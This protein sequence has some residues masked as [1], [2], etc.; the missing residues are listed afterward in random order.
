MDLCIFALVSALLLPVCEA[1][2]HIVVMRNQNTE[3]PNVATALKTVLVLPH[4]SFS[5]LIIY[6]YLWSKQ[7]HKAGQ[8]ISAKVLIF[9]DF[10]RTSTGYPVAMLFQNTELE[11]IILSNLPIGR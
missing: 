11:I 6:C 8:N 3:F 10:V 2:N 4:R 7:G 5:W 9:P 1:A